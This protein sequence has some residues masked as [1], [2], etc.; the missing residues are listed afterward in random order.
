MQV[1]DEIFREYVRMRDNGLDIKEALRALRHHIE[2]LGTEARDTLSQRLR[3]W[4]NRPQTPEPA[5]PKPSP[6]K[7]LRQ[8]AEGSWVECPHC[9]KKNRAQDVFCYSCGQMFDDVRSRHST[10]H[11]APASGEMFNDEYYGEDSMLVLKSRDNS[12]RFELRP[13]MRNREM[14]IG[15]STESD[16]MRPDI[17]LAQ[18]NAAELGVSRL[19]IALNYDKSTNTIQIYDLGSANG[20]FVNGQ[21]L[22]PTERRVLRHADELRMGRMVLKVEYQHPGEEI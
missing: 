20:T 22:H 21:K 11:F 7:P 2:P 6:I 1:I 12:V 13:Q 8:E 4:E 9:G 10:K 5:T 14:V 19:H 18:A 3:A 16:A 15:R 17:D